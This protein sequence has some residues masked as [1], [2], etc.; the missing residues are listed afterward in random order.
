MSKLQKSNEEGCDLM[1]TLFGKMSF[2]I[3]I[4]VFSSV[5]AAEQSPMISC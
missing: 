3:Y 4:I 1:L 2:L 5:K